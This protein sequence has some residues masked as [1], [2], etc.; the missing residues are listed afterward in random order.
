MGP[1]TNI[2]DKN[3]KEDNQTNDAYFEF[4]HDTLNFNHDI[5]IIIVCQQSLIGALTFLETRKNQ[6]RRGGLSI[7]RLLFFL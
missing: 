5:T 3:K 2:C 4:F 7:F 1:Q 6:I